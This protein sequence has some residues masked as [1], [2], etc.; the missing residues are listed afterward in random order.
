M[1]AEESQAELQDEF[2]FYSRFASHSF[3]S[4]HRIYSFRMNENVA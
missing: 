2:D 4:C 1:V 3:D